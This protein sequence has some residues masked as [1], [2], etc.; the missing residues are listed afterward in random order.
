MSWMDSWSRPGKH[1]AIP[2]PLYSTQ[3]DSARYCQSCGRIMSSSAKAGTAKLEEKKYCSSRC[4]S[5]KPGPQDRRIEDAFVRLLMADSKFEREPIP[6]ALLNKRTKPLKGDPRVI[7]PCSV[8]EELIFGTRH[9]PT[10]T[11]GRKKNRASRVIGDENEELDGHGAELKQ[12]TTQGFAGKVRPPQ[13]LTDIN[14]SIGG[15]KGRAEKGEETGEHAGRRKEGLRV[16]E[17]K[18]RVKRAARRGVVFGFTVGDAKE[19]ES[20]DKGNDHHARRKCEAMM[21]GKVVEPSF[22]KGDWGIRWRE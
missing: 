18:E 15:E 12:F 9:D 7:V 2:P 8:V 5:Q 6:E 17:E 3:G 19:A 10:K 4:R 20:E 22:A 14:G 21:K 13:H 11:S 16:T 1:A